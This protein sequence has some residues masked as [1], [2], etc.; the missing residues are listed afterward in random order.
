MSRA[1]GLRS[2][3][4][5]LLAGAMLFAAPANGQERF[6][7][8]PPPPDPLQE[9]RLPPIESYRMTNDLRLA[10]AQIPGSS[11]V[12]LQIV[13]LAGEGDSP[14]EM[15][16]LAE[17][18]ARLLRSGSL[19][20]SASA[21]EERLEAMA[22]DLSVAI[23][24]DR[25]V[26]S[27][28]VLEEFID[29]VLEIVGLLFLQP[30][31][32]ERQ[33]ETV[34]REMFYE[35]RG[36]LNDPE[37]VARRMLMRELFAGHPYR[38]AFYGEDVV[39]NLAVREA[40]A[41]YRRYY[42]PNNAI[43]VVAGDFNLP[44]ASRKV[45]HVLNT[46]AAQPVDRLPGPPPDPNTAARV[47]FIDAP[48]ARQPIL[49][50]GN[51]V[52]P[53]AG[54]DYFPFLVLNQVLGGAATSRLFMNLRESKEYAYFAFS[55]LEFTRAAGVY[56]ARVRTTPEAVRPAVVEVLKE[57]RSLGAVEVP[58]FEVEQAKSYLLGRFPLALES[59][60]ELSRRIALLQTYGLGDAHW[61]RYYD[62][63]MLVTPGQVL[64]AGRR[65]LQDPPVVVVAGRMEELAERLR[66]FDRVEIYDARGVL[67]SVIE[68][69]AER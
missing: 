16:G 21:V 8:T 53:M 29:R 18:T 4:A 66:E 9:L 6:R 12:S 58:A 10:V 34:R 38:T 55:E 24:L 60:A 62:S 2:A 3:P 65:Y 54:M 61:N 64:E 22:A 43:V 69:G 35:L 45:S 56:M 20:L 67:K 5:A 15:P 37:I 14:P 1:P 59:T 27:I 25:T 36:R 11:L 48:Q 17:F 13:I 47:C 26:F 46:W 28:T 23:F 42:R 68:K 7:K 50:A 32:N 19:L 30:D 33:A 49:I 51:L 41:F 57:M 44:A 31:F 63:V 40:A 52:M 39:R